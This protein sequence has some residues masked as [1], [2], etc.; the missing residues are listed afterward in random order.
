[1]A[2][3]HVCAAAEL[4]CQEILVLMLRKPLEW[5]QAVISIFIQVKPVAT[6]T[7]CV[8]EAVRKLPVCVGLVT[9]ATMDV[10]A[11]KVDRAVFHTAQQVHQCTAVLAQT[12]G[13]QLT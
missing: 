3:D 13:Q 7:A 9:K 5:A 2:A 11:H 6:Q 1:V 12:H 4:V 8:I 10:C